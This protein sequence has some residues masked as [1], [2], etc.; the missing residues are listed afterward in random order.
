MEIAQQIGKQRFRFR[1]VWSLEDYLTI[2]R[3]MQDF[4]I[5]VNL[6]SRQWLHMNA[7]QQRYALLSSLEEA[8]YLTESKSQEAVSFAG[9]KYVPKH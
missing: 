6:D 1:N 9:R 5:A 8:T 3:V 7:E 2:D 4:V